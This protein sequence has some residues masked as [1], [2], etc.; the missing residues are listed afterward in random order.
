MLLPRPQNRPQ[1]RRGGKGRSGVI[2]TGRGQVITGGQVTG[3]QVTGS[4]PVPGGGLHS[5]NVLP[6]RK[7]EDICL[8]RRVRGRRRCKLFSKQS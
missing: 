8:E 5:T 1:N 3:G 7:Y 2:F 6:K 4:V